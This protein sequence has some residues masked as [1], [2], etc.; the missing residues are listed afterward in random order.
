M[1]TGTTATL[2]VG[3]TH[4]LCCIWSCP[5]DVADES[6][7]RTHPGTK[8]HHIMFPGSQLFI[9]NPSCVRDMEGYKWP[10]L[11]PPLF[12]SSAQYI[13]R[14]QWLSLYLY[15]IF[16]YLAWKWNNSLRGQT[17]YPFCKR[18][19]KPMIVL[20]ESFCA[21]HT[22]WV[23]RAAVEIFTEVFMHPALVSWLITWV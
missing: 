4:H 17:V 19:C 6:L 3:H 15:V 21:Q 14:S 13:F 22:S 11:P 8:C 16:T 7:P 10:R 9:I 20:W 5:G 12:R 23:P 18:V 1:E 2:R